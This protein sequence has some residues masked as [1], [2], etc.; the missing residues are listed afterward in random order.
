MYRIQ[1]IK[2]VSCCSVN[3][4]NLFNLF[5]PIE[6]STMQL[7]W[8]C[9]YFDELTV[10]E[11]Y[12][13]IRLRNEVFVVEQDCVFQDADNIDQQCY[14]LM[15]FN[16]DGLVAYTR[17]VPAGVT[18]TEMSIGRVVNSPKCRGNGAGKAL[19]QQSIEACYRLFG[20][21]NIKI[22]AQLYL[23][24]FYEGFGFVQCSEVYDEDGI[25]HI[26]MVKTTT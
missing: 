22:G 1:R 7:Q 24:K 4:F 11:L 17:L 20:K 16:E 5:Q 19:M 3:L 14:H 26:K 13:I 21:Q 23:K 2:E 6:L 25:D 8:T 18:Y 12:A 15:G 10:H 9:K